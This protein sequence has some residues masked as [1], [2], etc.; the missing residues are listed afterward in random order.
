ME[1]LFAQTFVS[2]D[3]INLSDVFFTS[4]K[5]HDGATLLH[6]PWNAAWER[7]EIKPRPEYTFINISGKLI[8]QPRKT[9]CFGHSYTYSRQ[10]HPMEPET[11]AS[12]SAFYGIVLKIF[13]IETNMCLSN[14]YLHGYHSISAHSDDEKQMGKLHDVFCFVTGRT[15]RATFRNKATKEVVLDLMLPEGLYVMKGE[16]F[17]KLFTHEFPKCGDFGK[18][19]PTEIKGSLARADWAF[20]HKERVIEQIRGEKKRAK[21]KMSRTDEF[22]LWCQPRV[23]HTLRQFI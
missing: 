2:V 4:F 3:T 23:S 10:S 12:I 14:F 6:T 9:M 20:M 15:R 18:Y 19:A 16:N 21:T 1:V 17:Q 7:P 13:G 8:E 5:L 11:P 22:A